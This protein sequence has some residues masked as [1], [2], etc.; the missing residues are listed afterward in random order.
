MNELK[1]PHQT[2]N[3]IIGDESH[4]AYTTGSVESF[5]S[6]DAPHPS[7]KGKKSATTGPVKRPFNFESLTSHYKIGIVK[8]GISKK[9][10]EAIKSETDLDYN[11]LSV[12]LSVSRT[13]LIKKKGEEKFDR[14][15]SERIMYLAE[16]LDYGREVFENRDNF[17]RWIREPSWSLGGKAPLD[18]L[19]TLYG[20]EEVT[21]EL[22]RIEYGVY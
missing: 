7:P 19:D 8:N 16:V 6:E 2:N 17:N 11:T 18:M 1:N 15:T 9:Q 4:N 12:L 14:S 20:I 3:A 22:G 5:V 21:K 13:T 10:L